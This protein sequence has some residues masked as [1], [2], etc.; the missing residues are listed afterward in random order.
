VNCACAS[1]DES[2]RATKIRTDAA[3]NLRDLGQTRAVID[4]AKEVAADAVASDPP[5]GP[6]PG[7]AGHR[8]APSSAI[9]S[10][11]LT[12]FTTFTPLVHLESRVANIIGSIGLD[13][14]VHRWGKLEGTA[15]AK[16]DG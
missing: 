8:P 12:P 13:W 15:S 4:V 9:F 6:Y 7:P 10:T 14:Q 3:N 16:A 11:T 2:I 5:G 1:C